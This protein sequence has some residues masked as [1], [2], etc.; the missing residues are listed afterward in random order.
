MSQVQRIAH[1]KTVR[2]EKLGGVPGTKG[3]RDW[4]IKNELGQGR[5][6]NGR[7][8]VQIPPNILAMVKNLDFTP[9]VMGIPGRR[10]VG[11][12]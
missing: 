2:Q 11:L 6:S 8:N 1:V 10:G 5:W 12:M 3:Q 4:G 7:R 9:R